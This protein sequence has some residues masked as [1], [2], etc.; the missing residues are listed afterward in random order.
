MPFLK[1]LIPWAT[2]PINSEILPR[3]NSRSTT[4]ITTI[5]CQR[6]M[7][8]IGLTLR[9][10]G[11][12]GRGLACLFNQNLG[13]APRKNK[14]RNRFPAASHGHG[15]FTSPRLRGE[16]EETP[17]LFLRPVH[18]RRQA[19]VEV[20]GF[21]RVFV[22]AQC[23]IVGRLRHAKVCRQ[24]SVEQA[25]TL[26]VVEARKVAERFQAEMAEEIPRRPVGQR[27]ARRLAA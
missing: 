10:D 18:A 22:R 23:R 1:A 15:Y 3:P 6:L 12:R 26:K 13:L 24:G 2:S 7:E 9:N 20:A 19:K 14:D 21:Q 27:P 11:P 25:G 5:Q 8:P 4:P 17:I 16:G